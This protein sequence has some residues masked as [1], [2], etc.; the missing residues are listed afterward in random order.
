MIGKSS[1][2]AISYDAGHYG[3]TF[4]WQYHEQKMPNIAAL[5]FCTIVPLLIVCLAYFVC[6]S[7]CVCVC[8]CVCVS[9]LCM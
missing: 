2:I 4:S 6:V 5:P 9:P 7:V 1:V 3:A 8:V